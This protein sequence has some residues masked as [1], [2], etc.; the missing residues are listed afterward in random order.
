MREEDNPLV[1][2]FFIS[3]ILF[4]FFAHRRNVLGETFPLWG[5]DSTAGSGAETWLASST[6]GFARLS[7]LI[8][9]VA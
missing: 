7:A 5:F 1:F 6:T 4:A 8:S 3:F 9:R 2:F